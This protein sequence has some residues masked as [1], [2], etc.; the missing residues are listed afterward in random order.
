MDPLEAARTEVMRDFAQG[1]GD[2]LFA[3]YDEGMRGLGLPST[4][5]FAGGAR[6]AGPFVVDEVV[7]TTMTSRDWQLTSHAGTFLLS[8]ALA[9]DGRISMLWLR[10]KPPEPPVASSTVPLRLPFDGQWF[11]EWGGATKEANKHV[12]DPN[13][14]RASDLL[15][16][17]NG[18]SHRGD[19][20]ERADYYAY[21]RPVV[22]VA[23]AEVVTVLDGLY[24]AEPGHP[25]PYSGV[26]NM[27]LLKLTPELYAMYAHLQPGSMRVRPGD[28]VSAGQ[29]L[30]LCGNA[31]NS[32]EPHLHFQLQDGPHLETSYGVEPVFTRV[33]V[34]R[35]TKTEL[36]E[37][38]TFSKDDLIEQP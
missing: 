7:S 25:N 15:V 14:R 23:D 8:L 35:G 2:A 33:R 18:K 1:D 38:Y 20:K 22:A 9:K 21:G 13:E 5:E 12:V 36:I 28:H 37:R 3:K 27:I 17:E 16:V 30:A 10:P 11:V 19:G 31:G 24:E 4:R 29:P 6:D 32:T 26:G 34:T